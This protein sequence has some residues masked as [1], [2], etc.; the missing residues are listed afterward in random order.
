MLEPSSS[1]PIAET[2]T[3]SLVRTN[4]RKPGSPLS[5]RHHGPAAPVNGFV[6]LPHGPSLSIVIPEVRAN[7]ANVETSVAVIVPFESPSTASIDPLVAL[8]AAD[9]ERVNATI[10]SRTGSEVT[11]IPEVSNHLISSGG[12][13]LRPM[14]TLAMA[15][16]AGYSG[17]GHVKLAAA[18]EFMHTATLLHDDVVDESEL[19]RGKLSARMLWGNEASVLVGDFLL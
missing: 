12:K 16:L 14:L 10:L 8:V 7:R 6:P 1:A 5:A 17:D 15:G 9:M 18:V 2:S 4:S 3:I 19:R 13:R 11:M